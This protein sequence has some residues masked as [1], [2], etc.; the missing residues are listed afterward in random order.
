M[1]RVLH[2]GSKYLQKWTQ[3]L[4]KPRTNRNMAFSRCEVKPLQIFQPSR[5]IDSRV[6]FHGSADD[7]IHL[8]TPP[9]EYL[10][11]R[12]R[13]VEKI[14]RLVRFYTLI[15]TF[16]FDLSL[17]SYTTYC[18]YEN[19]ENVRIQGGRWRPKGDRKRQITSVGDFSLS[20]VFLSSMWPISRVYGIIRR[21]A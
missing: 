20:G 1:C 17:Y 8:A 16:D 14:P 2:L 5:S 10:A 7:R 11:W 12:I 18:I 19:K 3:K 21:Q 15:H 13:H 6:F 4:R 9:H